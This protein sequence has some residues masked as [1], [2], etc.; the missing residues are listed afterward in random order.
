MSWN[1]Q[2]SYKLGEEFLGGAAEAYE[3]M[4]LCRDRHVYEVDRRSMRCVQRTMWHGIKRGMVMVMV[5]VVHV[6]RGMAGGAGW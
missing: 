4:T 5:M 6:K 1:S 2:R 3:A